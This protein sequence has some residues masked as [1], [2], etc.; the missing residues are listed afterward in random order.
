MFNTIFDMKLLQIPY[1]YLYE[2][3]LTI[4]IRFQCIAQP[5]LKVNSVDEYTVDINKICTTMPKYKCK[6]II[7]NIMLCYNLLFL[8]SP[9]YYTCNIIQIAILKF[10]LY[11]KNLNFISIIT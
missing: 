3:L 6:C 4:P 11:Y 10:N 9:T 8:I 7:C 2:L 5:R 1:K